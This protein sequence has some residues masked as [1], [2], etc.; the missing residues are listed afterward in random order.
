MQGVAVTGKAMATVVV[1]HRGD[2]VQLDVGALVGGKARAHEAAP[3]GDVAGAG[4][5][6]PAQEIVERGFQLARAVVAHRLARV[7]Q[8]ADVE[9]V[10]QV[11]ADARRIGHDLDAMS[12]QF[13]CRA[14]AGQ[15]QQLRR[16]DRAA[17]QDDFTRGRLVEGLA[18]HRVR[19]AIGARVAR[20]RRSN[21]TRLTSAPVWM[22]RLGRDFTGLR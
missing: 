8:R 20:R 16:V 1:D 2:E 19:H 7:L 9:M 21:V 22:V 12:A 11:M 5:A 17:A 10:L 14:D 6:M 3:L 18:E 13:R 15:H 4:S